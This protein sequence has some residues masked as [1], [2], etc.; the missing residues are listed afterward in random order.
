MELLPFIAEIV[1]AIV[2]PLVTFIIFLT[3]RKPLLALIPF[4]EELRFK[5]Y[6]V[7]KFRRVINEVIIDKSPTLSAPAQIQIENSA[8]TPDITQNL[9]AVAKLSPTAAVI[10]AWASFENLAIQKLITLGKA[11]NNESIKGN[12]R[13]GHTLLTGNIFSKIDFENFHKLRE[14]RNIAAHKADMD[15][16]EDDAVQYINLAMALAAKVK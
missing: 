5:E 6:F 3:L 8:T 9:Y 4:I 15:L 10:Q 13:L 2:W 11:I 14:L 1:K 12:S 7:L 16:T